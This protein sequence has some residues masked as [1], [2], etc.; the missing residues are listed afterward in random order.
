MGD[1]GDLDYFK[2]ISFIVGQELYNFPSCYTKKNNLLYFGYELYILEGSSKGKNGM[3]LGYELR[4]WDRR[5]KCF[6]MS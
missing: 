6:D 4:F 2:R 5:R 1:F 3:Y